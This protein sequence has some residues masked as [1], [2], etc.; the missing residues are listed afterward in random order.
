MNFNN[1]KYKLRKLVKWMGKIFYGKLFLF[2]RKDI[3]KD[4]LLLIIIIIGKDI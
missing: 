1:N 4:M 2:Y 3:Y